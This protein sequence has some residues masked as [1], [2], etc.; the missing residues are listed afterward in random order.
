MNI[1]KEIMF[2]VISPINLNDELSLAVS[3]I[4]LFWNYT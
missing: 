1:K 3:I 2:E 4:I